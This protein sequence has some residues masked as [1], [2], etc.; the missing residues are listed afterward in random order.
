[1]SVGTMLSRVLG[2]IRDAL[3]FAF[4]DRTITDAFVVGFRIPNLFRRLLGEGSL[5]VSFIPVFV[6]YLKTNPDPQKAKDLSNATFSA[7]MTL[8][9]SLALL[10]FIYM[11][12]VVWLLVGNEQGYAAVPGKMDLTVYFSRIMVL[13]LILVTTYAYFMAI[14]NAVH[15]FFWPALAPAVFNLL[16]I[17]FILFP[18]FGVRGEVL[19]WGVVAGGLGQLLLTAWTVAKLGYFPRW[20]FK[21]RGTGFSWVLSNMGPGLLGLGVL[22][23]MTLVNTRLAAGLA[24]GAQSYIYA[25]DRILEL[26]QSLIAISLGTALLPR[27]SEYMAHNEDFRLLEEARGALRMLLYLS[28]PSAIGMYFLAVPLTDTLFRRGSFTVYDTYQTALVVQVYAALLMFSSI[29]KVTIPAFYAIKNTRLPALIAAGVLIV[30]VFLG[31][32][33]VQTQG[34]VGLATAT[35]ISGFLNMF[36]LQIFF[37]FRFGRLGN[38]ALWFSLMRIMPAATCLW[39]IC[40]YGHPL[41]SEVVPSR[42]ATLALDVSLGAGAYFLVSYLCGSP[43]AERLLGRLFRRLPKPF[44]LGR[45]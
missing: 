25:A 7:L 4:F 44:F 38:G 34:L 26:P 1:M 32:Q 29:S 21:W 27:Y 40:V 20:S 10:L 39:A 13:Y 36:V 11:E 43:E 45:R 35:A 24:E 19:A 16:A 18:D 33:L 23:V 28:I 12:E 15:S 17:M 14:C 9:T 22:Q 30:H 41:F 3:I 8:T 37:N 2:F 31:Y 5:S 42:V 6:E